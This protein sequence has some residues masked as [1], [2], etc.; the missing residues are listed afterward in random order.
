[1]PAL[2]DGCL[3]APKTPG[4]GLKLDEAAVARYRVG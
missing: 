1:M 2:E 4:L 3:V